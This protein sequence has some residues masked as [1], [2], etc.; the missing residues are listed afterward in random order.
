MYKTFE[1]ALPLAQKFVDFVNQSKSPWHAVNTVRVA[2]EAKGYQYLSERNSWNNLAPNG[3][4]YFTRNQS[5]IVA[6]TIG[7]KYQ[8]G[9]GIKIIGAHT[10]SPDL[11]LKP[12]SA[13]ESQGYLQVGVQWFAFERRSLFFALN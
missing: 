9:N 2:L 4:Y 5:T 13:Q 8:L 3:K 10:D 11:K 7:G 12:I 1:Q 6:F